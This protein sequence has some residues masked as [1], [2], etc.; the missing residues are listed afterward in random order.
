[1]TSGDLEFRPMRA[2]DADLDAFSQCFERN[3]MPRP[4]DALRWQYLENPTQ[5]VFVDFGIVD[6]QVAAIYAVLPSFVRV[7]GERRLSAQSVDSLVDPVLRGRGLFTKMAAA[8]YQRV[9]KQDGAFIYGFPNAYSGPPVFNKLGWVSLDPVPFLVRPLRTAFLASKLPVGRLAGRLPDLRLPIRGPKLRPTQ[10]L[11]LVTDFGPELDELWER[12]ASNVVVAVDRNADYLR[13]RL[14]KLGEQYECL[15]VYEAGRLISFCAYTVVDK[16]GGRVGY[17]VELLHDPGH[18]RAGAALLAECLR[19]MASDGADAA[20]AW[21]FRHSP[22][23]KAYSKVGFMPL[24]ERLRPIELH[25]GVK[26]L[27]DALTETLSDR[28]NWYISYCDSD[29]V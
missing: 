10:E 20:L 17:V 6:E 4:L 11:R 28:R 25:I 14:T 15:G 21:C 8:V 27:S 18:H 2:T 5:V 24:P 7:R 9:A 23:A 13:W 12:F 22:N 19:R 16:H 1:M 29:T 3:G 26:P